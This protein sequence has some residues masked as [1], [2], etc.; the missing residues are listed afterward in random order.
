MTMKRSESLTKAEHKA[1]KKWVAG[2]RI[3]KDASDKIGIARQNLY[4]VL[5][6]GS[7]KPTTIKAIRKQIA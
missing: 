5:G 2:H 1:F 7:G 3:K 4:S 6:S